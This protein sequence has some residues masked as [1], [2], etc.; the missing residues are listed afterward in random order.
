M[1]L[2]E[3]ISL[4]FDD[5][6]RPVIVKREGPPI[7]LGA[8]T[9]IL[10]VGQRPD[11]DEAA[12]L[13]LGRG[14]TIVVDDTLQSSVPGVFAT[15]DVVYGTKSVIAA[16]ASGREAA[17]AIDRSLGG[18][19]LIDEV[20]APVEEAEPRIGVVEGFATIARQTTRTT[21]VARTADG[22]PGIPP[23]GLRI[24]RRCRPREAGD[25]CSAICAPSWPGHGSGATSLRCRPPPQVPAPTRRRLRAPLAPTC[26]QCRPPIAVFDRAPVRLTWRAR[27][28]QRPGSR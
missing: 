27:G 1:E 10:A 28:R 23:R 15:G 21:Q 7:R 11:L 26:G 9:V 5:D 4:T 12:G 19:G 2:G 6:R 24:R 25:A 8:D 16:V 22:R 13:A 3:V 20:L 17:M 14:N 18:D